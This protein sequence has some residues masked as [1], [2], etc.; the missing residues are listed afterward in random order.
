MK[1]TLI[2]CASLSLCAASE[3]IS[4]HLS[5]R[6]VD[7]GLELKFTVPPSNAWEIVRFD[8]VRNWGEVVAIDEHPASTN[9]TVVVS[10][11]A[12]AELG[13]PEASGQV[14][15]YAVVFPAVVNPR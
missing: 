2:L 13:E 11:T 10:P 6:K 14:Y 12:P 9:I 1:T 3:P 7:A 15:F 4:P 5:Y 8:M